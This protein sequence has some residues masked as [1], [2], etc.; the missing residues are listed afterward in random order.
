MI[1]KPGS[2]E[3]NDMIDFMRADLN[4]GMALSKMIQSVKERFEEE[5][6]DFIEEYEN[7]KKENNL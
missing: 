5:D 6:R 2:K 3:Y 1:P 7:W 4:S